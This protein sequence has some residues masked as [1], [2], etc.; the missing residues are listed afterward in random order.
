MLV[1]KT[2][3]YLRICGQYEINQIKPDFIKLHKSLYS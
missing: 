3:Y 2:E 1:I